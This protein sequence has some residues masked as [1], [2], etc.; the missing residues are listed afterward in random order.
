MDLIRFDEYSSPSFNSLHSAVDQYQIYDLVGHSWD[1]T[2]TQAGYSVGEN[3]TITDRFIVGVGSVTWV[4]SLNNQNL[5][6]YWDG[7]EEVRRANSNGVGTYYAISVYANIDNDFSPPIYD[8]LVSNPATAVVVLALGEQSLPTADAQLEL[9]VPWLIW[10]NATG[11][12]I[13]PSD[14]WSLDNTSQKNYGIVAIQAYDP[15]SKPAAGVVHQLMKAAPW[16]PVERKVFTYNDGTTG[17]REFAQ[18]PSWRHLLNGYPLDARKPPKTLKLKSTSSSAQMATLRYYQQNH[19]ESH[20][21][22]TETLDW[23]TRKIKIEAGKEVSI[24]ITGMMMGTLDLE[25]EGTLETELGAYAASYLRVGQG[26]QLLSEWEQLRSGGTVE[27]G[28][29]PYPLGNTV[30]VTTTD[31]RVTGEYSTDYH[32]LLY[33]SGTSETKNGNLKIWASLANNDRWGIGRANPPQTPEEVPLGKTIEI[34]NL[35]RETLFYEAQLDGSIGQLIMDSPRLL[36][37]HAALQADHYGAPVD[38][39]LPVINYR[40]LAEKGLAILGYRPNYITGEHDKA[41]EKKRVRQ[42]F[43]GAESNEG[44]SG[45]YFGEKGLVMR[46]V[47]NQF[48]KTGQIEHGGFVGVPDLPH[49]IKEALDQIAIAIGGQESGA[50]EIREGDQ[51]RRYPNQL[52]LLKDVALATSA[53]HKLTHQTFLSG[54]VTQQQTGEIIAGLGLPTVLKNTTV[55]TNGKIKP[56]PYWGIAPNYSLGKKIDNVLYNTGVVLGQVV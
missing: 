22:V 39:Q 47:P 52:E 36:E 29:K 51:V 44:Y 17:L 42:L 4:F 43:N 46:R 8:T 6:G 55:A 28:I 18:V 21:L 48:G 12:F 9:L 11:S 34:N 40:V 54:V 16:L 31:N 35:D 45:N 27:T 33:C 3:K 25:F 38:G 1:E 53:T 32:S 15:I 5:P 7:W 24:K 50:I 37:I 10:G 13:Y 19:M 23:R 49:L 2:T 14:S 56:L 41:A 20:P 30:Y 26:Q